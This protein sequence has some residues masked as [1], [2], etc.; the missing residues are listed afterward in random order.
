MN[1]NESLFKYA[2]QIIQIAAAIEESTGPKG[3]HKQAIELLVEMI[4]TC[5]SAILR[6]KE[7]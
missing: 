6:L 2:A 1:T 5:Q 4:D 3:N 7:Q